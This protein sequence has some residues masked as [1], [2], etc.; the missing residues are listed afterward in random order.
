MFHRVFPDK[1]IPVTSLRSLYLSHGIKRKL[2]RKR[3]SLYPG[4]EER[5][6]EQT[7]EARSKLQQAIDEGI[8]V[9]YC[10][11]VV[12]TK[13]TNQKADFTNRCSTFRLTQ[14]QLGSGY[15]SA[16]AAI[17]TEG[18]LDHLH[19]QENALKATDF[20]TF[21][22]AIARKHPG[23]KLALYLDRA[24]FHTSVDTK[25]AYADLNLTPI[26]CPVASPQLSP[27]ENCFSVV[28]HTY[29]KNKLGLLMNEE[30][31]QMNQQ[32]RKAFRALKLE[33]IQRCI[34]FSLK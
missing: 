31:M 33:T 18:G 27:P 9:I 24:R 14:E 4:N 16:L 13:S 11:E 7:E 34:Q 23:Q 1:H 22:K 12:F 28:K 26:F 25:Q 17:S 19:V 29:K 2:I 32:I 15:W 8:K 5:I 30:E 10:D 20:I 6:R 21:L 3:K